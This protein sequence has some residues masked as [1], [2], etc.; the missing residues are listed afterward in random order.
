MTKAMAMTRHD[1]V[2]DFTLQCNAPLALTAD[3]DTDPAHN[4][5]T[6]LYPNW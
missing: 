5:D 4:G 2:I 3:L 1:P 6:F